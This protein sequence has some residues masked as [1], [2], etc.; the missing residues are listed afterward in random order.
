V[1]RQRPPDLLTTV[2]EGWP[3]DAVR[4][5]EELEADNSKAWWEAH[6]DVYQQAVRAPMEALLADLAP[7]FGP[8][9]IFR[10]YRDVRFSADKTPYKTS[11]AAVVGGGGYVALSADELRAGGG[12]V[13]LAPDQLDRYRRAVDDDRAGPALE[14]AVAGIRA[15]GH[16]VGPYGA[17]KTAPRGYPKDHPRVEL[18]RAK[19]LVMWHAW[20]VDRWL[21]SAG[22]KERIAD[23]LRA[24]TPLTTWLAEHVGG[25]TEEPS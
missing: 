7:E 20:P 11:I 22:S 9:R 4:F 12:M 3:A 2:F 23:V 17:L 6:K 15:A 19:G 10:P 5:F 16:E 13:H 8:G 14:E 21:E 24:A 18:L 25:P 1:G